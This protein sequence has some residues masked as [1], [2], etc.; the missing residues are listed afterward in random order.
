[1]LSHQWCH[2][3]SYSSALAHQKLWII[4]PTQHRMTQIEYLPPSESSWVSPSS[5]ALL[6][7]F[8]LPI[9]NRRTIELWSVNAFSRPKFQCYHNSPQNS[10]SGLLQQFLLMIPCST[11]FPFLLLWQ[12][13]KTKVSWGRNGLFRT[14]SFKGVSLLMD[15]SLPPSQGGLQVSMVAGRAENSHLKPQQK[16]QLAN[17]KCHVTFEITKPDLQWHTRS[18]FL[19]LHKQSHKLGPSIQNI[20]ALE[21]HCHSKLHIK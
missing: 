16:A 4:N 12:N 7:A 6:S 3:H 18:Y 19:H 13:T 2:N 10:L 21:G 17:S 8:S 5:F 1:M 15:S 11:L 9:L 20:C 14:C